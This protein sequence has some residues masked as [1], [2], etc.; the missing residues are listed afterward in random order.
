MGADCRAADRW[1]PTGGTCTSAINWDS[2]R[3]CW[4][5]P[6]RCWTGCSAGGVATG[7]GAERFSSAVADGERG[8]GLSRVDEPVQFAQ[9][10]GAVAGLD[11]TQ[12]PAS[13]DRGELLRSAAPSSR[14]RLSGR[15]S[16]AY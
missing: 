2:F 5:V 16:T 12:H 8:D 3:R 7:A 13:A 4:P 6:G 15:P 9:P 1:P 10:E 14:S 11:V